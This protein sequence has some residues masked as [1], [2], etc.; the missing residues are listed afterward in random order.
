MDVYSL[1][2]YKRLC[3]KIEN[4]LQSFILVVGNNICNI[5]NFNPL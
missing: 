1:Y 5:S 4:L 2:N 3:E